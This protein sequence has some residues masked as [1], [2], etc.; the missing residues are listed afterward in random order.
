VLFNQYEG[1]DMDTIAELPF[2]KL[3][4]DDKGVLEDRQQVARLIDHIGAAKPERLAVVSHGWRNDEGYAT[5]LYT[6]LFT[7]VV[8]CLKARGSP[9][10]SMPAVVGVYWPAMAL[11]E[12]FGS[13]AS[14][15][16]ADGTATA[17]AGHRRVDPNMIST[18]GLE[19]VRR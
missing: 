10:S 11:P 2:L 3:G 17:L 14:P 1:Y 18:R 19:G 8:D 7:N 6:E 12:E 13:A 4:F 9:R 5:A 15:R 16:N